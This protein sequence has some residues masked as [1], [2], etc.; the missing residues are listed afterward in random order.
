MYGEKESLA[1][2]FKERNE[3][4]D[5]REREKAEGK[6]SGKETKA[7]NEQTKGEK[8]ISY[9]YKIIHG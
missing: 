6:K 9:M 2:Y 7:S 3:A 1:I 5:R 4:E 8:S